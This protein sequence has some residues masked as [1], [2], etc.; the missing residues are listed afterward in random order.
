[1]NQHGIMYYIIKLIIQSFFYLISIWFINIKKMSFIIIL[2]DL[3]VIKF[4]LKDIYI[5]IYI[6]V[7]K[8]VDVNTWNS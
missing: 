5:Y 4:F 3:R 7:K 2:S 6:L 1:M 8:K